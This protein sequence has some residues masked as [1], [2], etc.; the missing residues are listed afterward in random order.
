M[1]ARIDLTEFSE[2]LNSS[3][4]AG[5]KFSREGQRIIFDH[6]NE[7]ENY[8]MQSPTDIAIDWNES[9]YEDLKN[10]Y[11]WDESLTRIYEE[12]QEI[13]DGSVEQL[14]HYIIL[15]VGEW[16]MNN[17]VLAGRT[18]SAFDAESSTFIYRPF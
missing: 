15:G 7:D 5:G 14:N 12:A 11:S 13:C 3:S 4:V 9:T 10:D 18:G 1:L 2:R 17:T 6:L 8:I 16:L